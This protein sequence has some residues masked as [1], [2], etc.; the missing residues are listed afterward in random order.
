MQGERIVA[1]VSKVLSPNDVGATRSHQSG[2]AVPKTD[3]LD[4]FPR[5]DPAVRNPDCTVTVRSESADIYWN[6]RYVYYNSRRFGDG[7][8]DEYR[9]V[10]VRAML[11]ELGA[12]V[13]DTIRFS[14]TS[15]GD[16]LVSLKPVEDEPVVEAEAAPSGKLP[17]GWKIIAVE[18]E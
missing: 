18:D 17:G 8:R 15:I 4:F 2:I 14:R 6:L 7:T 13:G 9:L 11:D 12:K 1:S 10:Q 5:L 16:T 3:V